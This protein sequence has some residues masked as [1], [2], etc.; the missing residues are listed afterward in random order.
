MSV[1][2]EVGRGGVV[3]RRRDEVPSA[4]GGTW[5]QSLSETAGSILAQPTHGSPSEQGGREREK[6]GHIVCELGETCLH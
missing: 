3:R 5:P 4:N 6:E 2:W 1:Q